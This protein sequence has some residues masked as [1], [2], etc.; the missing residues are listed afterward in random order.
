MR[1][2]LRTLSVVFAAGALGGAANAV[3]AW[4]AGA[5]GISEAAGVQIA[6]ALTPAMLYHRVVWGGLWGGLFL[7]G[8]WRSHRL[9]AGA[10]YS[11]GPTL[12][13]WLVV[14]PL[15]A[16]TGL[17][18]LDLG[19]WTPAFVVVLNLIWGLVAAGWLIAAGEPQPPRPAGT[20]RPA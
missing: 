2:C 18:G 16:G 20:I 7:L 3:A 5:T 13:Q 19:A 14:F 6:P 10:V 4:A 12:V 1:T 15:K 17:L 8:L 11:L 9:L